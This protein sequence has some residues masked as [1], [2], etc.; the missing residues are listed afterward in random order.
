MSNDVSVEKN[1][2][3]ENEVSLEKKLTKKDLRNVWWRWVF[4]AQSNYSYERLQG[5]GFLFAMSPVIRRLY[6]NDKE[7]FIA[8]CKRHMEFFNTEPYLGAS[9]HG[10]VA[11]MEE[12]RANGVPITDEAIN[13]LKTGLMG[14][15]AGVGDTVRQGTLNPIL[16]SFAISLGLSGN[17]LG[18]IAYILSYFCITFPISFFIFKK[19]YE[20][21]KEG[22]QEIFASG[23]LNK[24]MTLTA[25]MGAMTL[26]ALTASFVV[27]KSVAVFKVGQ[28][29][30][31]LQ[32]HVLDKILLNLLPLGIT[33][34]TLKLLNKKLKSTTVLFILMA[35]GVVGGLLGYF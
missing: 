30:I 24:V 32:T 3:V 7:E 17:V 33:L 34:L 35:I 25:T 11:A 5:P 1:V 13:G 15:I 8:A 19:S 16:V 31:A 2:A 21:G 29:T 14:P 23:I 18:P 28:G 20:K 27:L 9:I 6:N 4:F 10:M 12:Q 26:G 22:V